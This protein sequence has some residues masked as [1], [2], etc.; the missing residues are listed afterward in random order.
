[1]HRKH[2]DRES[3]HQS[4]N[5]TKYHTPGSEDTT[6]S[7]GPSSDNLYMRG[8]SHQSSVLLLICH[9]ITNRLNIKITYLRCQK[10]DPTHSRLKCLQNV[11]AHFDHLPRTSKIPQNI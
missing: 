7:D 11:T 6:N 2:D 1:M 9:R 5:Y 3:P 8:S 4:R 10:F